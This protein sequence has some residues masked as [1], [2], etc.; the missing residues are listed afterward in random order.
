MK[1][2]RLILLVGD[3][4]TLWAGLLL[5]LLFRYGTS[6]FF[7]NT[8]PLHIA[9]FSIIFGVWI[10]VF[11]IM[12]LYEIRRINEIP[13]AIK[14]ILYAM[15][16]GGSIAI[17]FFYFISYFLIT[18][19]INLIVDLFITVVLLTSWRI[20][21]IKRAGTLFKTRVLL[22]GSSADIEELIAAIKKYPQLGYSVSGHTNELT[23]MVELLKRQKIDIVVALKEIESQDAFVHAIYETLHSG[24]RF[25]DAAIFYENILGKIPV[26][27]ISKTWFL[28]NI[29]ETEKRTFELV[30][31]GLDIFFS[32]VLGV[33][34][35]LF[36][37][38]VALV[39]KLDSH[40]PVFLKQKRVGRMGKIYV[41][42]KYR[43]MVALGPDGH[44]EPNGV[45]WTRDKDARITR[46]GKFLRK[47]RIDELPQ[48]W[49]ILKGDLSFIGPRPERP[50]FVEQLRKE[51]P[52]YDMRHLIRPGLSGWAQINPPYYYGTHKEA[53]LKMQY[54]LYYI[55]N[56]DLGLDLDI[57]LKTLM[58]ILTA[59][60]R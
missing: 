35:L 40:G 24:V 29:A 32:L 48:L 56:R 2:K 17:S 5:T 43:T 27:F 44:A 12:G 39:I 30:K 58:V 9:P 36:F 38:F 16:V 18:P 4:I 1:Q 26:S 37:P 20:F 45:E 53:T 46:V 14:L 15:G 19:R 34:A 41:H 54:D 25:I 59:S 50:E 49:N 47:T 31:R 42:Y 51:I 33:V 3:I 21:F 11:Y 22:V 55:K 23:Q 57:M 6:G 52:F 28:E 10:L 60:G 8:L 13:A 7:E